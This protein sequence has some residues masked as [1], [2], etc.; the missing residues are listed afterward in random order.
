MKAILFSVLG[1]L[2]TTQAMATN[3][4]TAPS[5][6]AAIDYHYGMHLDIARVVS[7]SEIPNVC[8]PVPV[9]M[10]YED[11]NGQQHTIRYRVMG[12]GCQAG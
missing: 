2:M 7:H 12:N 4:P 3:Q 6:G 5:S 1:V 10:T 11:S 8:H 9:E